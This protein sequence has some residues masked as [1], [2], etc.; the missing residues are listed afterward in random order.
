MPAHFKDEDRESQRKANPEAPRH[1]EQLGA[2][3]GIGADHFRLKPHAADRAGA[4]MILSDL[5]VH[6]TG[7]DRRSEAHTSELQSLMR[8]SYAV[9]CLKKQKTTADTY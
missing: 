9:F 5:G 7:P 6:R 8:I 2:G 1:V 4:G 3:S